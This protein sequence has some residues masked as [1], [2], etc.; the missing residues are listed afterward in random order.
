MILTEYVTY[1]GKEKRV[2]DLSPTSGY[3][4]DVQCP[5]CLNVRNVF[6]SSVC[7]AG[8]T[9]CQ[10]CSIKIKRGKALEIGSKFNRLTIIGASTKTGYSVCKCDCGN[11]IEVE[12]WNIEHGKTKSCG[13]LRSENIKRVAP[14]S[15]KEEHWNWKGG[16]AGERN[17]VMSRKVYKDWRSDVFERDMYMCRKCGNLGRKLRAHHIQ[18]YANNPDFVL[19]PNNGIT[20]CEKCHRRFHHIYGFET[21]KEQLDEFLFVL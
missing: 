19:D 1:R 2:Q 13:C 21:N 6:Y 17:S 9:L 7:R 14:H 16:I 12:N 8:H 4:V 20:L 5:N 18:N 15:V 11:S 10:S 3:K